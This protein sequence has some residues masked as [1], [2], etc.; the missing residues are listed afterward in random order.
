MNIVDLF[1][2]I[3]SKNIDVVRRAI[4]LGS[5][6]LN[7]Y[8]YG[9]TPLLYAIECGNE[10][11]A[12]E[13]LQSGKSDPYLKNN[14]GSTCLQG[15]IQNEMYRLVELLLRRYKRAELSTI[16]DDDETLMT[17]A[18]KNNFDRSAIFLINGIY[19]DFLIIYF[20]QFKFLISWD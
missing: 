10:D 19:Y 15:A 9:V 7:E 17:L 13:F 3:K 14:L 12:L 1:S 8:C 11:I 5:V 6:N 20:S 18:L 4:E 2:E 16:Y